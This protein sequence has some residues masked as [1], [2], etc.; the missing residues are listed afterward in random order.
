MPT[1]ANEIIQFLNSKTK[2]E[3]EDLKIKDRIETILEVKR[4]LTKKG[5]ML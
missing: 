5:L 1:K 3:I 2:E 4:I